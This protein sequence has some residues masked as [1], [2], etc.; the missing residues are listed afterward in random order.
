MLSKKSKKFSINSTKR[1]PV[2]IHNKGLSLESLK[3]K[4]KNSA[5]DVATSI[6]DELGV[7]RPSS[8]R[9]KKI[10][11]EKSHKKNDPRKK[12][13]EILVNR[14]RKF[15]KNHEVQKFQ[16]KTLSKLDRGK[17]HQEKVE[18]L[19]SSAEKTVV[20]SIVNFGF[21][22]KFV[23]LSML[24]VMGFTALAIIG[25]HLKLLDTAIFYQ[26]F[27]G[28]VHQLEF[29][30]EFEARLVENGYNRLPVFVVEGSI[31]N[32]FNESDQIKKIQL[33]AIAFDD[34]QR[35]I[36]T[37][38]TYAG[39]ILSDKQLE[40]MSP[41]DIKS[42]RHS[43]KFEI[44]NS[45]EVMKD[46]GQSLNTFLPQS[47]MIPFQA[48]FIKSVPTIKKTSLQIVS[49]VRNNKIVYVHTPNL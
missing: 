23:L 24:M 41:L 30:G 16:T 1:T 37:H 17:T 42:L 2:S 11:L 33:K 46:E 19:N 9:S 35:L 34:E 29:E 25:G 44:L 7:K 27:G 5:A 26:L 36:T 20:R 4:P 43:S 8:I 18:K 12:V 45:S 10:F 13:S 49:Y 14:E 47:P 48:V 3:Q 21:H 31:R 15:F 38:F 22:E 28:N 40:S 32:T 6:L 39:N